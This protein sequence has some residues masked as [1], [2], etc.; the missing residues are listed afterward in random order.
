MT[1]FR[2]FSPS[3]CLIII[4]ALVGCS[5]PAEEPLNVDE[6]DTG[7]EDVD[8]TWTPVEALDLPNAMGAGGH[9]LLPW[10][11]DQYIRAQDGVVE[12][13][14]DASLLPAGFTPELMAGSG[15]SRV[16]PIVTWLPGGI[17]PGT[18]P[19]ADDWGA[20]LEEESTVAVVVLRDD[21]EPELWPVLAEID[22]TA[23]APE[24]A[25]LLLRPHRPFPPGAQV[26]VGL[27]TGLKTYGCHLG[28]SAEQCQDHTTLPAL[29]RILDGE[30]EGRA[31]ESWMDRERDALLTALPLLGPQVTDLVQA[32][33]FTVRGKSEV[34][35]PL[36]GMQ[37]AA[38][39]ADASSYT[40]DPVHYE[41]NRALIYGRLDVPWFLD[42]EDRVVLDEAGAPVIQ[43]TRS[44][45]FLITIPRTVTEPRPVVL[46]GHGF[47]SSIEESTWGNLFN[48]LQRWEM[49]AVTTR[50]YG[51]AEA[52]FGSAASALAG[53]TFDGLA[54]IIDL[55]RQSQANFTV[56]H[57]MLSQHLADSLTIEFEEEG[58]GQGEFSPLD[59]SNI[60]YMGI[61]NGGTQGLVMMSTSPVL[62]RGALVVPGG[63]WAHMLQRAS[64]WTTLGALLANR[65]DSDVELQLAMSLI[66]HIFDPVD[67]LNFMEHLVE[68]RLPGLPENPQILMVEAVNDAQVAN[69]V[70]RWVAAA[71]GVPQIVPSV[72]EIWQMPTTG[73]EAPE[74]APGGVGFEL[75]D[76]G[77]D[78]NPPGNVAPTENGVH[79][80]VRLLDAYREQMGI[81]LEDGR[82]VRTCDGPCDPE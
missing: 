57:N 29:Q 61:S 59:S 12:L 17:D 39:D 1:N 4:M 51:F 31:E 69:L 58:Q 35:D 18:L 34:V 68:D 73:A 11:S 79:N 37:Q 6:P 53:T 41:E 40:L 46:F 16:T 78:D 76:L 48:G 26:A 67:S 33:T 74:G 60:P 66:Q 9:S 72:A 38:A 25:T 52:D 22:A 81:F 70:T 36:V 42:E 14:P 63:G 80:D 7:H 5:D 27:R 54:G 50:F 10:P 32:W 44:V 55:Q 8:E 65:Y 30:P 43:E 77:V 56:V 82:V 2:N 21:A 64:Q 19:D 49:A 15:V 13:A 20:S 24:E 47:F 23:E 28:D 75:Y 62:S 3:L 45:R 71:A